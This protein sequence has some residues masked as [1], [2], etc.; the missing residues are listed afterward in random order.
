VLLL[1]WLDR[2]GLVRQRVVEA[3]RG[4]RHVRV[5]GR[6]GEKRL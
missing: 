5:D 3:E 2:L 1:D 4:R 6:R